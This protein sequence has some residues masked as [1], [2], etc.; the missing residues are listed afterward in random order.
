MPAS[1]RCAAPDG[2]HLVVD[3]DRHV[4]NPGHHL[5]G[6][7]RPASRL[8]SVGLPHD[9]TPADGVLEEIESCRG[10]DRAD[11][12]PDD[13]VGAHLATETN[14]LLARNVLELRKGH[15]TLDR[16]AAQDAGEPSRGTR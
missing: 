12:S 10:F 11:R 2:D 9:N 1:E 3:P 13:A 14:R 7:V 6:H 15:G 4:T 5:D 8:A 16:V